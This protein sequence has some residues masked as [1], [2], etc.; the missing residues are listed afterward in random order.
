MDT[1]HRTHHLY[2]DTAKLAILIDPNGTPSNVLA[3]I[4]AL[5]L[6]LFRVKR[7]L[8]V[9][10]P[11]SIYSALML[12]SNA[13]LLTALCKRI[14]LMTVDPANLTPILDKWLT[15]LTPD[16]FFFLFDI[17]GILLSPLSAHYA[18]GLSIAALSYQEVWRFYRP[19]IQVL[20]ADFL[21][22]FSSLRDVSPSIPLSE[23]ILSLFTMSPA[24]KERLIARILE[25]RLTLVENATPRIDRAPTEIIP[26]A[27]KLSPDGMVNKYT[28]KIAEDMSAA[29]HSKPPLTK[30][31][32]SD[33]VC[34]RWIHEGSR[35]TCCSTK[36][37]YRLHKF[38]PSETPA[39]VALYKAWV[40]QHFSF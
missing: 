29:G 16:N 40:L 3:R 2:D 34:F 23:S 15:S 22:Q 9:T 13:D 11:S 14:M 4:R 25:H 21:E 32:M 12:S 19:P 8:Y 36:G 7:D 39:A 5:L 20:Q 37:C 10:V 1:L 31:G 33:L 27:P 26:K 28:R 38:A 35:N 6:T 18:I 24:R 30:Q 17:L